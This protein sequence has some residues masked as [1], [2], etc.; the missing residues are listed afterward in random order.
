MT[1]LL[2]YYHNNHGWG[3]YS[4]F[5]DN[6]CYELTWNGAYNRVT[7][8][9]LPSLEILTVENEHLEIDNQMLHNK[10]VEIDILWQETKN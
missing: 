1:S 4:N 2:L 7:K 5:T 6:Y 9:S 8:F 10:I 3:T